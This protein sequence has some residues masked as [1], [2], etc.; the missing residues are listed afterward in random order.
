MCM[1]DEKIGRNLRTQIKAV[2]LDVAPKELCSRDPK[3]TH[4]ILSSDATIDVSVFPESL[5]G[6]RLIG[7]HLTPQT[8]ILF[9]DIERFGN[10]VYEKW[11]GH[12]AAASSNVTVITSTLEAKTSSELV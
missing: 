8:P 9:I 5:A 3:R 12:D 2:V 1:E 7:L 4:I 11:N 10:L 6:S